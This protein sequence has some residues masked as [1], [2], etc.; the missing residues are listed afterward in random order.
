MLSLALEAIIGESR[1]NVNRRISDTESA[2][3]TKSRLFWRSSLMRKR[4]IGV[5]ETIA[6]RRRCLVGDNTLRCESSCDQPQGRGGTVSMN[7]LPLPHLTAGG[8]QAPL[9][10][11][12]LIVAFLAPSG[13][14]HCQQGLDSRD[15]SSHLMPTSF[16]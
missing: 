10:V 4:H 2:T 9:K 3:Q 5:R 12:T 8:L 6:R 13:S 1:Q 15:K 16:I 7:L 11:N 14:Q